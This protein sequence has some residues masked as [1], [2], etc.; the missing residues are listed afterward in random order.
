MNFM[1][2]VISLVLLISL[3]LTGCTKKSVIKE[4]GSYT[5]KEDVALYIHTYNKLPSNFITKSEARALGWSGGGLDPYAKGK[6]IGG[7]RYSNYE[8]TLPKS[9]KY[10]ECDIETLHKSKRGPKRLVYSYDG[11]IYY[12][13]DHYKSFDLLYGEE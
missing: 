4:S 1:K 8:G 6:C 5:S 11:L 13:G 10:Y 3:L 12:T 2:R 9:H 7:D